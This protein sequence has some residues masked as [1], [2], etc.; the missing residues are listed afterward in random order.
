MALSY[1]ATA[2]SRPARAESSPAWLRPASKMGSTAWGASVQPHEPLLNRPDNALL[3]VPALAVRAMRGKNAARAAPMLALAAISCCSAW[4]MSGRR[5]S[6]S[7]GMPSGT[8]RSATAPPSA[9]TLGSNRS[10][11][12]CPTSSVSA[13]TSS[14]RRRCC[15]A[16][17]DRAA[18]VR[19]SA[20]RRSR[21]EV[22]PWSKRRRLSR[23]ESSR[24]TMVRCVRLSSSSLVCRLSQ[25]LTT[26]AIRLVC[27]ALRASCVARNCARA[28]SFRLATRPKKSISQDAMARPAV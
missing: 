21:A 15:W 2:I 12:G 25:V 3:A 14:A 9:C 4:R 6:R 7:D 1:W 22:T 24:V 11:T 23:S 16:R 10:G 18:A 5:S 27:T 19:D 17:V 26:D 20:W 28:A 13:F 8:S